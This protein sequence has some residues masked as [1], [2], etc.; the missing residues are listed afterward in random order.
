MLSPG[1]R[2]GPYEIQSAVW[3]GGM[4]EVY[5][6][7]DTR[8]GR[9]VAIKILS[10]HLAEDPH[11][12][13]WLAREARAISQLSHPNICTLYDVGEA[14]GHA[15]PSGAPAS[16]LVMQFVEGETLADRL[17]RGPL[18]VDQ[19]LAYSVQMTDALDT[20][21]RKGIVHRDLKPGNIMVTKA[22]VT[23]L[24]FGLAEQR[25]QPLVPGWADAATG[26][27]PVGSPG[28]VFGTLQ[29]LAPEQLEGRESDERTDIFA[30]GAVIY[31]MMTRSRTHAMA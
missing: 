24:D 10:P 4:G 16:Y 28:T 29:Y 14:G 2:L 9:T 20:A 7:R 12:R 1:T 8:L 3:S 18:P 17:E 6:A 22:G 21:H 23:Q 19:A 15:T 26:P 5:K 27:T 31:E 30:C 13:D 11:F 25:T